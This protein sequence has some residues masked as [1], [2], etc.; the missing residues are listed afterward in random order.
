MEKI[1]VL[2]FGGQYTHLIARRV[3][4]LGVYSEIF[5]FHKPIKDL[6]E[7]SLRGLILSGGPKSVLDADA[8]LCS[9]GIFE[10]GVPVLGI[11]YGHQLIA[12]LLGGKV[13][14]GRKRE[15]GKTELMILK[16]ND[17]FLGLEKRQIVWMS[18]FDQVL[19]LPNQFEA[20]ASTENTKIAAFKHKFK[21]IYGVQ[22]HPEVKHTVNGR[23]ML[24]NF[25][26]GICGCKGGW[27]PESIIERAV[28]EI[29]REVGQ[30]EAVICALSGGVDS[31]TT[32]VIVN[33]AVGDR[34][35]CIF[36]DHGLLRKKEAERI[37]KTLKEMK[38]N[39][40]YVDAKKRFLN[41]I[42]GI[43]DPEEK[44]KVIGEEFIKIFEEEA[45]KIKNVKWLAQGTIYPDRVESGMV[46]VGTSRIKS[47]HNVGGL[48]ERM[49]LK[50]IEPLKDLYKDEV[51]EVARM[52]GLPSE[53]VNRHP[54]P[55]PGLAVRIIGEVTPEK[56]RICKETD[57]ILE[58]EL[59]K[60]GYYG[61]VWQAFTVVGNDKW[62][63]VL[64]D[65]RREG[66]I[67]TI[68]I[69]TSEDGM[70]ADWFKLPYELLERISNR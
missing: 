19:D 4:E 66:Y 11:C 49:N 33:K 1:V 62:T 31:L 34:L 40:R 48:P 37:L 39:V 63:G 12:H 26:Y 69:V 58:E 53:I 6:K 14:K 70:T 15:Y 43:S 2:D 59:K 61:K 55:G 8:P 47:H 22:F 13:S 9:K 57:A 51:R 18:H 52:L 65:E 3:R 42:K 28:K 68:R 27:R 64:G 60:A 30:N 67:V 7:K 41:R 25:L 29:S 54:F 10:L 46:G 20:L 56:L 21:P 44:R 32:A 17:L 16:E 35:I 45:G 36:V 24:K 5:P 38:L 23:K 50:L